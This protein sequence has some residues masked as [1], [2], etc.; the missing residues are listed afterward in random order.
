[1]EAF[2][3]DMGSCFLMYFCYRICSTGPQAHGLGV[4]VELYWFNP[5]SPFTHI[6][7]SRVR[8]NIGNI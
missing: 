6:V 7:G 5:I 8:S 1:M 4:R 3:S 2:G